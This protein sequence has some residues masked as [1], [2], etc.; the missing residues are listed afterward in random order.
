MLNTS[1]ASTMEGSFWMAAKLKVSFVP[2]GILYPFTSNDSNIKN[3]HNHD[4]KSGYRNGNNNDDDIDR[5]NDDNDD[6]CSC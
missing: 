4:D 6:G 2:A 3:D 5:G 1:G